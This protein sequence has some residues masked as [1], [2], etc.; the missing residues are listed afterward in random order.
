M[1]ATDLNRLAAV[2]EEGVPQTRAKEDKVFSNL[3]YLERVT[4]CTA[5][6]QL[7]DT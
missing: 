6:A 1:R 3:A 5:L 7:R 4:R 2:E